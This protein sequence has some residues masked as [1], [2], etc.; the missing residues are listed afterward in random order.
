[1]AVTL[2][3]SVGELSFV[4]HY[5]SCPRAAFNFLALAAS[6]YYDGTTFHRNIAGFIA[7]GGDPTGTG[8]GGASI[9]QHYRRRHS[10]NVDNT[11]GS[12]GSSVGYFDDEGFGETFHNRRGVLSMAHRGTKPNTNASQ[13]FITYAPLPSFDGTYTAFGELQ[14]GM[15]VLDALERCSNDQTILRCTVTHNP[16]A[17]KVLSF[18]PRNV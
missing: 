2:H 18:D 10:D 7:Q 3:T 1:M 12:S 17:D 16:F 4:L 11:T 9:Y 8:K 5:R 14:G 13:F 15:D 6:G